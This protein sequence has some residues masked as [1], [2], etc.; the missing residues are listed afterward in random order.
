MKNVLTKSMIGRGETRQWIK[1]IKQKETHWWDQIKEST[2]TPPPFE[3]SSKIYSDEN[4]VQGDLL[5][6]GFPTEY[7]TL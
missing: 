2:F 1:K 6:Y 5:K 4:T 3:E 7:S